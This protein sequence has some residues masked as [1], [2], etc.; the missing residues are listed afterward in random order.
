VIS[1]IIAFSLLPIAAYAFYLRKR[2]PIIAIATS[3][4]AL[5]GCYLAFMPGQMQ[6]I[7]DLV[8]VGR[9]ADLLFYIF[10]I[11]AFCAFFTLFL[12][13]RRLEDQIVVLSREIALRTAAPR[14]SITPDK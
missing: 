3:I 7:A 5:A 12:S 9:G 8:G 2:S 10:M 4:F 14:N 1:F 13:I 11:V 6:A